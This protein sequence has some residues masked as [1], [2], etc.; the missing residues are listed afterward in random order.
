MKIPL[1]INQYLVDTGKSL[2]ELA[3]DAEI[4]VQKLQLAYDAIAP[5]TFREEA[6]LLA[7][8]DEQGWKFK[9]HLVTKEERQLDIWKK[10][11][12]I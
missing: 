6:N 7:Y 11:A 12:E 8:L 1:L 2:E 3:D 4:D 5:L 9:P 10:F